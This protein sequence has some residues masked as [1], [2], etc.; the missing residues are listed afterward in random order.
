ME[1][2]QAE[3]VGPFQFFILMLSVYVLAALFIESVFELPEDI[4]EVL[5]LADVGIC[6]VFLVDFVIRFIKPSN[7]L[8]FMRWGWIDLL[9]SIPMLDAFR[10]GRVV[11]VVRVL[12]ILKAARST[13]VI[14]NHVFRNKPKGTFSLVATISIL[15]VIFGAIAMLQ[16]EAGNPDANIHNAHDA[17]WWAFVTITTVGYGDFYPITFEGRVVA[18]VIMT[19]GVGLFGSF[20]AYV[21]SIFLEDT[22]GYDASNNEL[23]EELKLL[24]KEVADLNHA[25]QN[26]D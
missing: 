14:L 21:A 25:N 20:T 5:R 3:Q 10:Y 6:C 8:E 26:Q 9:S 12:R 16:L 7:K 17:L 4:S 19:A 24:R 22:D 13:K 2:K 15:L 1:T 18:G 11:R 23:L